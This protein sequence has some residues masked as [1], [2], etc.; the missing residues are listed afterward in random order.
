MIHFLSHMFS[1]FSC[2]IYAKALVV[3]MLQLATWGA[4]QFY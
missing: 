1:M 2:E 4:L 3:E